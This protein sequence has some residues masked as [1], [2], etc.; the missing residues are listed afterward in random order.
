MKAWSFIGKVAQGLTVIKFRKCLKTLLIG[1]FSHTLLCHVSVMLVIV[2]K[3]YQKIFYESCFS[4]SSR[5]LLLK[6]PRNN[7]SFLIQS[8]VSK[9]YPIS[10]YGFF[11]NFLCML[12]LPSVLFIPHFSGMK[13]KCFSISVKTVM[14][15]LLRLFSRPK[16]G[17]LC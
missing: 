15:I 14:L 5:R 2:V 8:K 4:N 16:S 6:L 10:F 1:C 11:K 13:W 17:Y 9:H 7:Q 12:L 3:F